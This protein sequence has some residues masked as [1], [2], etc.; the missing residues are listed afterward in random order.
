MQL[1]DYLCTHTLTYIAYLNIQKIDISI[2]NVYCSQH[3][4]RLII[5]F[6]TSKKESTRSEVSK[7]IATNYT[8]APF[9]FLLF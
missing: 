6:A 7:E 4:K 5:I 9:A 2:L 3:C 1:F 8:K